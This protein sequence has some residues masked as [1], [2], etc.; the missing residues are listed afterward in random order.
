MVTWEGG[1]FLVSFKG[2]V[3]EQVKDFIFLFL[4]L[5]KGMKR[6]DGFK[7]FCMARGTERLS[8]HLPQA[9]RRVVKMF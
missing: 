9:V 7:I 3:A 6:H 8:L 2:R 4:M 5:I 1:R